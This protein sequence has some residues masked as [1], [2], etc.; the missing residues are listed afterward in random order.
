[1]WVDIGTNNVTAKF[2][3]TPSNGKLVQECQSDLG[4]LERVAPAESVDR[5]GIVG[6]VDLGVVVSCDSL[7]QHGSG[8]A[9][10][11]PTGVVRAGVAATGIIGGGQ[12]AVGVDQGLGE[13]VGS[14]ID[15][16]SLEGDD[17]GG[18]RLE[19][20]KGRMINGCSLMRPDSGEDV[21]GSHVEFHE[22]LNC[23]P[24]IMVGRGDRLRAKETSFLTGVEVNL[25]WGGGLEAGFNQDTE[26]L[27]GI[28]GTGTILTGRNEGSITVG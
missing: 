23:N 22:S 16:V 24:G 1:L 9:V 17:L 18:P 20:V 15:V 10:L 6:C 27:N 3:Q 19:A 25:E 21:L 5:G 7:V 11:E 13:G 8:V 28:D 26:D 2:L 14:A 4:E 12:L